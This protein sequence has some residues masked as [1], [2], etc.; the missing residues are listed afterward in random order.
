MASTKT[1]PMQANAKYL[2]ESKTSNGCSNGSRSIICQYYHKARGE[3]DVFDKH[4]V[5]ESA[6]DR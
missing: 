4:E 3:M 6:S 1:I 2:A 5:R